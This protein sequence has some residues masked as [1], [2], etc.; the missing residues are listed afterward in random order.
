[1]NSLITRFDG[2]VL[3]CI[4]VFVKSHKTQQSLHQFVKFG[5][6]GVANTAIDFCAYYILT[7]Y[8]PLTLLEGDSKYA[9]AIIIAFAA[10]ATFSY[11][12]NRSWTFKRQERASMGEATKFYISTITALLLSLALFAVLRRYIGMHDLVAKI[13]A[14]LVTIFWNFFLNRLWVFKS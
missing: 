13:V 5:I 6:I 10:A 3:A 7:R 2:L 4:A 14:T 9:I 1:M 12:L 8:S 11:F